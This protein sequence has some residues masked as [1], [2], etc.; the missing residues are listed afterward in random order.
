MTKPTFVYTLVAYRE[1]GVDTCRGCVMGTSDSAFSLEVF[2]DVDKLVKAWA[3]AIFSE[4]KEREYCSTDY[5]LLLNGYDAQSEPSS[6]DDDAPCDVETG[7]CWYEVE[8]TRVTTLLDAEC[9]QVRAARQ[10]EKDRQE[11]LA[12]ARRLQ[13]AE[14]AR[15]AQEAAERQ[16]Y[17]ALRA[18]FGDPA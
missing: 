9:A 1:N 14:Q 15:I 13:E 18:K 11:Q 2:T 5:T 16:Q 7:L 12:E 3:K 8:R 4:V 17:Q 6:W 10:S